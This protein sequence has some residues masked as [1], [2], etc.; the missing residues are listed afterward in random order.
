M[1]HL[2]APLTIKS[3]TL[4]NRIGVS[5]MCMY[6]SDDGVANDWHLVHLGALARGGSGLVIAEATAVSPEGRITPGDAGLWADRQA[7]P[8][9][10]INRFIKAQGAVPG[11]QLAHAGRKASAARP[12]EGGAHLPDENGGWTPIAPSA[13]AF[14]GTLNKVPHELTLEE[15]AR[16]QGDFVAA[17]KRALSAGYEWVELH[18]AHGY[19]SHEFLSPLSNQRTDRYGG[20]FENRIRFLVETTR[21]VRA[22][23][24]E[25]LPLTV[26]LSCTDWVDGGWTIEES[27]ELARVLKR[28]GVDLI[29]CSSGGS[30]PSAKVP[31]APGYQ[32]GFAERVRREA[33]IATAAVGMITEPKQAEAIV[34]EEKADLVL[35]AREL[36]RD[37]HWPLRAANELGIKPA[38]PPPVQYARAW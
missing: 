13:I 36:L 2:F 24:P 1:S 9:A 7:E 3:I 8:L 26:R 30:V 22:V 27:V 33:G 18:S 37:P 5:P 29:D 20:S 11:I 19:L 35:L 31:V 21:A 32:V 34:R 25:R 14:G 17:A 28:E 15:I 23:W 4:R 10:R 12:W 16:L 38:T 6:S